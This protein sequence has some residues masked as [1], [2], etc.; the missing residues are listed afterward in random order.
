MKR[1]RDKI[2]VTLSDSEV[3]AGRKGKILSI[4][5]ENVGMQVKDPL[6]DVG[7]SLTVLTPDGKRSAIRNRRCQWPQSTHSHGQI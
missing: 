5:L 7:E 1:E 6:L 3:A 2:T 4:G